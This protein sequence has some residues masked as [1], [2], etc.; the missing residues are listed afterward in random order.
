MFSDFK[1]VIYIDRTPPQSAVES[2]R[3]LSPNET[4]VLVRSQ[5]GTADGVHVLANVPASTADAA[6]LT[7]VEG[8]QGRC[9][10]ID[11]ALFRG[12][13]RD[14]AP[15]SASLIIVTFE[16]TGTRNIQRVTVAVP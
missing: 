12:A 6:I 3:R 1:R 9:D 15:G 4:E 11:R 14:V 8:G 2:L 7:M 16:P 5:D 10:R 13:V